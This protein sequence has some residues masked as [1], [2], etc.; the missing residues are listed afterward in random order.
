MY[1][2]ASS[3]AYTIGLLPMR[4]Q[5]KQEQSIRI[6]KSITPFYC[7]LL[8]DQ[9]RNCN[10]AKKKVTT[11]KLPIANRYSLLMFSA[12]ILARMIPP[13]ISFEISRK[14]FPISDKISFCFSLFIVICFST[15]KIQTISAKPSNEKVKF[16]SGI[17]IFSF[18]NCRHSSLRTFPVSVMGIFP[19]MMIC[20]GR[21]NFSMRDS[22]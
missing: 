12:I 1:V 19:T 10:P 3:L 11:K 8:F 14:Y 16:Q 15:P 5:S 22:I 18:A 9:F 21:L 13:K 2:C 6:R 4:R 17:I 7:F 20:F